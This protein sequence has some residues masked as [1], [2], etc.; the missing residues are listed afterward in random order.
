MTLPMT[1][2]TGPLEVNPQPP[3]IICSLNG[4]QPLP[5]G[6]GRCNPWP[7]QANHPFPHPPTPLT[8]PGRKT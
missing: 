2:M 6:W 3:L 4:S 7:W 1:E 8:L 5:A